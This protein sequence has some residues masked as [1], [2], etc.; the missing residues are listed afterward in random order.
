MLRPQQPQLLFDCL[1]DCPFGLF[2]VLERGGELLR[3]VKLLELT[4]LGASESVLLLIQRFPLEPAFK[5]RFKLGVLF[6]F[7]VRN[8]CFSDQGQPQILP[9]YIIK[10]VFRHRVLQVGPHIFVVENDVQFPVQTFYV[11]A[12]FLLQSVFIRVLSLFLLK[13][14]PCLL[15]KVSLRSVAWHG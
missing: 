11:V 12:E 1:L 5:K 15:K 9:L 2:S 14:R 3:P 10:H 4:H 7:G 6:L 8:F 13:V